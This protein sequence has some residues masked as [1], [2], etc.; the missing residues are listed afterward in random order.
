MGAG[1][2]TVISATLGLSIGVYWFVSKKTA[3]KLTKDDLRLSKSYGK[4]L[5]AVSGPRTVEG[6]VMSVVILLQRVF[7]IAASGTPGVSLFNVPFRYVTLCQCPSEAT[8]MAMVPVAAA[9][10]GQKDLEKMKSGMTYALKLALMFS[11]VLMVVLFLFSEVLISFFT[12]EATMAEWKDAFVWNMKMYC[13]ILPFFTIQ[14]IG[15]SMLQAMKKAKRPMEVTMILGVVRMLLFWVASSY[16][17]Q[18]ITYALIISY[19]L[20]AVLMM[21]MARMEFRKL[22]SVKVDTA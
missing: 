5:M 9:A 21:G 8:G 18:A 1:L 19:V 12:N 4:E 22:C 6:I 14:T 2:A 15:S 13:L 17:Y 7:I 20:S 3:I 16:D 11:L 10:Y